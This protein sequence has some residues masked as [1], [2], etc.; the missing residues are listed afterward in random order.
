MFLSASARSSKCTHTVA[1]AKALSSSEVDPQIFKSRMRLRADAADFTVPQEYDST[2][3][4]AV[5]YHSVFSVVSFSAAN[6]AL[7]VAPGCRRVRGRCG[8]VR[9]VRSK[10]GPDGFNDSLHGSSPMAV[11]SRKESRKVP[12][13]VRARVLNNEEEDE[14]VEKLPSDTMRAPD[15]AD[16][17]S[18]CERTKRK[19]LPCAG[20]IRQ[21]EVWNRTADW[22]TMFVRRHAGR[23]AGELAALQRLGQLF[24]AAVCA[25]AVRD[26]RHPLVEPFCGSCGQQRDE[27]HKVEKERALLTT[28]HPTADPIKVS[29]AGWRAA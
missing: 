10:C 8:H 5:L 25:A 20:E 17:A 9:V 29:F 15:D 7:C 13:R 14:G 22:R 19:L 16:V 2:I 1:L 4:W 23:A 27:R 26:V 18:V 21:G 24:S 12:A 11:K 6:A 28:H 3:V